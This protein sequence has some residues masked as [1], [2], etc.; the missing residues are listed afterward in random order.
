MFCRPV[1]APT[2][3]SYLPS[4]VEARFGSIT[5]PLSF[6]T[7]YSNTQYDIFISIKDATNPDQI[8]PLKWG[9]LAIDHGRRLHVVIVGEDLDVFGHVHPEDFL[10]GNAASAVVMSSPHASSPSEIASPSFGGS[11][12]AS[13]G[14]LR[15]GVTSSASRLPAVLGTKSDPQGN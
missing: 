1:I 10:G 6:S 2:T 7:L 14:N 9:D 5:S 15:E 13:S 8:K 4:L 11:S 12:N 3:T